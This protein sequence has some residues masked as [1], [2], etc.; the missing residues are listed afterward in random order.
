MAG[1]SAVILGD[2]CSGKTSLVRVLNGQAF[3]GA[4]TPTVSAVHTEMPGGVALWDM[5]GMDRLM[6][7]TG[8]CRVNGFA[9]CVLVC[10][11]SSRRSFDGLGAWLDEFLQFAYAG[12]ACVPSVVVV[13]TKSDRAKLTVTPAELEAFAVSI[14]VEYRFK[15]IRCGFHAVVS[16]KQNEMGP[17]VSAL[18]NAFD[19]ARASTTSTPPTWPNWT[20]GTVPENADANPAVLLRS[21]LHIEHATVDPAESS[22]FIQTPDATVEVCQSGNPDEVRCAVGA[23]CAVLVMR[24]RF[25]SLAATHITSWSEEVV[26]SSM[27]RRPRDALLLA[28]VGI[29]VPS[30]DDDT[31][32]VARRAAAE[33]PSGF[34]LTR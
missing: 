27:L 15:Q 34:D 9:A 6:S 19:A 30:C 32:D 11:M 8:G 31:R 16:S 1:Q 4:Y 3:G 33:P 5:P 10:D 13:G 26:N 21:T 29:P 17:L 24:M 25:A 18:A 2:A 22:R 7:S 12:G 28:V 23:D 14:H 20:A